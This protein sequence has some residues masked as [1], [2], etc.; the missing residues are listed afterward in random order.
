[1]VLLGKALLCTMEI[2]NNI[3]SLF[4][5]ICWIIRFEYHDMTLLVVKQKEHMLW[6]SSNDPIFLSVWSTQSLHCKS[7]TYHAILCV[8]WVN[9][10]LLLVKVYAVPSGYMELVLCISPL[11]KWTY[12]IGYHR[13]LLG[14]SPVSFC[15]ECTMSYK[16]WSMSYFL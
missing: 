13:C 3:S 1:M 16:V 5:D 14:M 8:L 4:W 15:S 11:T 2:L 7:F 9:A 12:G 10:F 6:L